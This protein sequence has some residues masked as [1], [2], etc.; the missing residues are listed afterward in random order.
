MN[1]IKLLPIGLLFFSSRAVASID[2]IIDESFRPMAQ[3]IEK[4]VFYSMPMFGTE[5]P[6]IVLLLVGCGLF[7]TLYLGFINIRGFGHAVRIVRGDFT[8]PNDP[9]EVSHFQALTTAVSGTVG[10]GNVAH[11]AILMSI[12]G[13]GAAFWLIV[14]GFLGM[15]SKFAECTLG[16]KYRNENP[17]GTVF[18]GPMFYLEKGLASLKMP[19]FG[20][21]LSH[22][23]AICIVIGTLGVGCMFQSN[24]A[25]V[26]FVNVTGADGSFFADK[27]W[28]VGLVLAVLTGMVI[29]GGI[30]S[31][32]AVTSRLV[33]FMALLY[34]VTAL[35]VIAANAEKLP[36]AFSA[37]INGAFSPE[38]VTGGVIGVLILGFRR[39]AFS[40]EAGIGSS[41]IAHS[42]VKT[43]EP[44]T[45][46]YVA[47]LEPF[48]DTVVICTIT[49]LVIIVTVYE[50]GVTGANGVSG[51][52]LTSSAFASVLPW[53]PYVLTVVIILFAY[54]TMVAWSYYGLAGW[55]YLFGAG[56][57]T[58]MTYNLI[59]CVFVIIGCA[60]KLDAVLSF[61]DSMI[62]A[63]A[64]ANI[65]GIVLLAPT[66]KREIDG[67]WQRR[68]AAVSTAT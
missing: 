41:S 1:L 49:A 62:F 67:Y 55:V 65:I 66:V 3:A 58:K 38:G 2:Q 24:Q 18:G 47:M 46:G 19:R 13:P 33:P 31:I 68:R 54:S 14:A 12:G 60:V 56:S 5:A 32:A 40:N 63:M 16:V 36:Y 11:V 6:V 37:I 25:Y 64:L 45:E 51:V 28:L 42:A 44:V 52:E 53:F 61:S 8:D 7:F 20:K 34:L 17:D 57:R 26:Q 21:V 43:K 48:I 4:I 10:V 29:V 59:F 30:K 50:P 35:I 27:A 22:Y 39:A 15:S 9:G 23:Y